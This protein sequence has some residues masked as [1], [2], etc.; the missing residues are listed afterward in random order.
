MTRLVHIR[1]VDSCSVG[2]AGR[3]VN[4]KDLDDLQ[5][6][7]CKSVGWVH[8]DTDTD[9]VIFS[10]NGEGDDVG[11]EIC[12]PKICIIELKELVS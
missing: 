1:W 12:I 4:R 10:H 2:S 11:G 7:E 9:I 6:G 3:W 5:L 8:R